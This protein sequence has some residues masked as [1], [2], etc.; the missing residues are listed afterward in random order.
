MKLVLI[1]FVLILSFSNIAFSQ[2]LSGK[3][4]QI[5][6]KGIIVDENSNEPVSVS[7]E[8]RT[9]DGKKI[10]T[11]S[12]SNTGLF[13]QLLPA[14]ETY[15]VILTADDILRKEFEF[16]TDKSSEY[17]EQKAEWTVVKPKEGSRI[18]SGEIFK[19]GGSGISDEGIKKLKELQMLLRFNRS[20][21]VSFELAGESSLVNNRM[22]ELS[23]FID[24]WAREKSRIEIK[25]SNKDS[26]N[27]DIYVYITKIE[28]FLRK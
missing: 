21:Y 7:I 25:K 4:A 9:G 28:D 5:L 14:G 13:E 20:L 19:T 8:L 16:S 15:N 2:F 1:T 23:K 12:N 26:Q 22:T 10:K 18:F 24:E 11:Q 3:N 27:K 6:V 17:K